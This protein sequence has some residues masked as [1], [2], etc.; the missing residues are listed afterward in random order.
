MAREPSRI[1]AMAAAVL[2]ELGLEV[3]REYRFAPP[4]DGGLISG[5]GMR[6]KPVCWRSRA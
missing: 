4:G 5:S 2:A 1:E 6:R 3:E